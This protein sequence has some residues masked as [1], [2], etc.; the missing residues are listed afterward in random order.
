MLTNLS[1]IVPVYNAESTIEKAIRSVPE[2]IKIEIICIDDC[3]IDGSLE[4]IKKARRSGLPFSVYRNITN[5]GVSKSRNIGIRHASSGWIM[6]LDADDTLSLPPNFETIL[7]EASSIHSD[8]ILFSH[9]SEGI[10]IAYDYD[11]DEGILTRKK[12]VGLSNDFLAKPRGNSIIPHCWGKVYSVNFLNS[13]SIFFREDLKIYEDTEFVARCFTKANT[14]IY[15]RQIIYT[16]SLSRGLSHA[17]EQE[18]TS[19]RH[20]LELFS[21][22]SRDRN[23]GSSIAYAV[24]L[25]KTLHLASTL[26]ILRRYKV[27][28][29]IAKEIAN[30]Y[31][32]SSKVSNR[33]LGLI[34]RYKSYKYPLLCTILLELN[35]KNA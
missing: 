13:N 25:S 2:S 17:F 29:L 24:Y 16:H 5:Q 35:F 22:L 9:Y 11:I 28:Q 23:T 34:I 15:H 1:V 20:C 6:F 33:L 26:P 30:Q 8:L 7:E 32:D 4:K 19:F 18:P 31:L 10:G 27:C 14:A 3:S 21:T 12:I